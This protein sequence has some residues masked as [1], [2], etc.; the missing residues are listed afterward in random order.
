MHVMVGLRRRFCAFCDLALVSK[1]SIPSRN[2]YHIAT[3]WIE[4]S[5]LIEHS[6]TGRRS[7]RNPS[8]SSGVIL[9]WARWF[10]PWPICPVGLEP[11]VVSVIA[12]S[13]SVRAGQV[14]DAVDEVR[15]QP[16]GLGGGVDVGEVAEELSVHHRDLSPGQV[17]AEAEVRTGGPEADVGI[18]MAQHVEALGVLEHVL[19]AV[20]RVVEE[21]ALV[22]LGELVARQ[23]RR[24]G[25]GATHE[26]DGGSPADD[27]VDGGR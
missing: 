11:G 12:L 6:D 10:T 5:W 7:W 4:P 25:G 14:L 27:L 24:R 26:D 19:V 15:A 21:D 2:P 22:T 9:I 8:I 16:V 3:A 18:G 1:A 23:R 17:G 20:G 13:A